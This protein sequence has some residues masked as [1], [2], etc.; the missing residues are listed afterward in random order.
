[1]IKLLTSSFCS[2]IVTTV[3]RAQKQ[4]FLI[5]KHSDI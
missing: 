2:M 4:Q 5:Q 1:M 3:S